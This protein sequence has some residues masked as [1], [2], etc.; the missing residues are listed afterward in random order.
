[1][2][3]PQFDAAAYLDEAANLMDLP[4]D[5]AHRPGVIENMAR[6]AAMADLVMQFGLPEDTELGPVFR[7]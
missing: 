3:S 4:L 7:P 1:M 6:L 2:T 5:P